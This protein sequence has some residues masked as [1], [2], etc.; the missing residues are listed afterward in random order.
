VRLPR[1]NDFPTGGARLAD[2]L[3][4]VSFVVPLLREAH[5]FTVLVPTEPGTGVEE[6]NRR[7]KLVERIVEMERPAHTTFEIRQYWALFR[8]GEA[9]LGYDTLLDQGARFVALVLGEN[10]L[11]ESYLASSHPFDIADRTVAGRDRIGDK[12]EL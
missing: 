3:Q 4:F 1:E 9:R 10:H 11:A 8:I 7:L 12:M 6:V 2:W 5:R